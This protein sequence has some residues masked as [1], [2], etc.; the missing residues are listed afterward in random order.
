MC[1]SAE[2]RAFACGAGSYGGVAGRGEWVDAVVVEVFSDD[3]P[4]WC[5]V[6][7]WWRDGPPAAATGGNAL[8]PRENALLRE[9]PA[10][11][12]EPEAEKSGDGESTGDG[13]GD[14]DWYVPW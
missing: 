9:W 7:V 1:L 12:M 2:R 10:M 5:A 3:V 11:E 14:M 4:A 13:S 6:T 8:G